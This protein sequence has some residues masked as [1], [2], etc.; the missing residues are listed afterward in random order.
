MKIS[1]R[2]RS[3]FP[4]QSA[5]IPP[6]WIFGDVP[7]RLLSTYLSRKAFFKTYFLIGLVPKVGILSQPSH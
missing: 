7:R 1:K 3:S 2:N 6:R 4:H 5:A